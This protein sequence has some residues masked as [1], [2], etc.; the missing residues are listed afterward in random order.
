MASRDAEPP[1]TGGTKET[2]ARSKR[3][4]KLTPKALQNAIEDKRREILK[5]RR[6][7]LSVMQ[8]VEE[9][10]DDSEIETVARDLAVVS[11][12][13]G[14][15]LRE[16]LDLYEQDSLG[17]YVEKAQLDEEN[18]ILERALLLVEKL[19]NRISRQ[20]SKL[21]ELRSVSSR[22]SSR[23][24]SVSKT[25]STIARLQALA[26]AKAAKTRDAE[27]ERIRQQEIAQFECEI[28]ILG[29]DKKAAIA[30]AKLEDALLEGDLEKESELLST[31]EA[32]KRLLPAAPKLKT[33]EKTPQQQKPLIPNPD[34]PDRNFTNEDRRVHQNTAFN[35]QPRIASTPFKDI[36]GSQLIDSLTVVNQQI[37]AG[38]ARQNL[39]KCQPDV[40]SGDPTLFHP[41]RSAF[42]A[43][44][45]DT[46][47]SP[48]QEINYLRSFTS[49]APQRLVD[50]YR[51]RQ[52]RDPV[53]LLRDLWVE[54]E[55]RF[56]S[57]AVI[58]NTLLE[59]LR[60]TATFSEHEMINCN[61]SQIFVRI[62]KVK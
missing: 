59:R 34:P 51:K 10:S 36:T 50:N 25:S 23:R 31:S 4:V 2:G 43:M 20:S 33:S 14:K 13:F 60:N 44:L 18:Q 40:F 48:T 41:W 53:A 12:E 30:N 9:L 5:S 55:K 39:P 42:K 3:T 15:L 1:N 16:L 19:K 21:L 45:M 29:A 17:D 57:A 46:D 6:R 58:S 37:V 28:A 22:H 26:D 7:L 62:L 35:R 61:S 8:S 56:G 49:G 38:L 24:S 52:M 32:T 47:V 54:L 11:E 27:A